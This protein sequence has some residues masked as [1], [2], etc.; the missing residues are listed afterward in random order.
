[1]GLS[2]VHEIRAR[3]RALGL[4]GKVRISHGFCLGGITEKKAAAVVEAM[5]EVGVALGTHGAG[6]LAV[7]PM[8]M[9]RAAGFVLFAGNDDIRDIW[10]PYRRPHRTRR[11]WKGDFRRGD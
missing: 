7:P 4:G 6:G 3:T 5:A 10:S 8:E 11:G 2:Y 9:L 1:M